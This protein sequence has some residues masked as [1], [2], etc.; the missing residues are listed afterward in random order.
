M[1][2]QLL[3]LI[4]LI[5]VDLFGKRNITIKLSKLGIEKK[6]DD[7]DRI[8]NT[9]ELV[10]KTN[11]NVNITEVEGKIPSIIDLATTNAVRNKTPNVSDLGKKESYDTKI[12][13]KYL[14]KQLIKR[15]KGKLQ[16][17]NLIKITT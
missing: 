8:H 14:S 6:I 17:I 7:A 5:L 2:N 15:K 13:T 12:D 4:R 16:L 9:I 1:I 3:S 11:D 10:K